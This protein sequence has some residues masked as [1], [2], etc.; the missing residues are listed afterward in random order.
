MP[1]PADDDPSYFYFFA[2]KGSRQ[3]L[4]LLREQYPSYTASLRLSSTG[5]WMLILA[6][7][8]D[9]TITSLDYLEDQWESAAIK[10]GVDYDGYKR[11]VS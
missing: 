11:P 2:P 4:V 7:P 1:S 3:K 5:E 6:M 10:F 8:I 9:Y